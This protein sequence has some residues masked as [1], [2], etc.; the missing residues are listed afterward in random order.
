MLKINIDDAKIRLIDLIEEVVQGKEIVI[1]K[2]NKPLAK[3]VPISEAPS[4]P[5]FGSAR[6]L[7]TMSDDFDEPLD[8]FKD[9]M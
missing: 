6:G 4:K 1:T 2:E 3:L 8:D 7:I 9:Y 5:L